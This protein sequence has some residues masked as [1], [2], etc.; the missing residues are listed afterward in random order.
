[1]VAVLS[2]FDR[3]FLG[4]DEDF[5]IIGSGEIG[6][7]A[8]GLAAIRRSIAEG[9][10]PDRFPDFA[11]GIPRS[12]VIATDC[13]DVFM[14][15]NN[16]YDFLRADDYT[17]ERIA[18]EFQKADL[19]AFLV[20]DLLS[21][22]KATCQPLA[23]RSSSL[24]EDAKHEPFAGI[25]ETKMIPNNQHDEKTR[26]TRLIEAI[27]FVYAS[28][29]FRAAREYRLGTG[30]ALEDEKM[31]VLIQE[32][33]G[34]RHTDRFY[35]DISGVGRSYNFYCYGHARPDDGVVNLALGLGKT[36]VDGGVSWT[37]CPRYPQTQ[38]PYVSFDQ[39]MKES[40]NDFW[41]V[42]MGP[43]PSYDPI[44]ETEYLVRAD[45]RAAEDD[46]TLKLLASTYDAPNNRLEMGVFGTG[47]RVITF[48]PLLVG[49]MLPLNEVV[50]ALLELSETQSG[51][52]VEIEFAVT[53]EPD[54]PARF[55]FLQ[56]RPMVVS[57]DKVEVSD[58]ELRAPETLVAA[59]SALGNGVNDK[60]DH[61]VYL[62]P[63][64]FEQKNTRKI[65]GE[66]SEVNAFL[67]E[68]GRHYLLIG[69]G[70]WGSTDPWL[71]I[72]VTWGQIGNARAI[73]EVMLPGMY[74]DLSQGSHFFHNLNG[75]QVS[76]FSLHAHE[77]PVDWAALDTCD[78]LK[79]T[80]H[81]RCVKLPA[82]LHIKVDGR[83]GRGVIH[84]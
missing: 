29:F 38:P 44:E 74:I 15:I 30:H 56:V 72:P 84:R 17:D 1:M 54:G 40:Q 37:Y 71:G 66:L 46:N 42:N 6:G 76:Y 58:E 12:T 81:V 45:L 16:L 34:R 75:F 79:E 2:K 70:R 4:S 13:F 25:Y 53:L 49:R 24:L 39:L 23:V 5:T 69:F 73:V 48:A 31:A 32:V 61:V 10:P 19:P 62:K 50:K 21:I 18:M 68:A 27:K 26:F 67:R 14:K 9:F 63:D 65:V 51:S 64:V 82:P 36:I 78:A 7:K 35:P 47:P 20:G 41:A 83:T 8:H 60:I 3:S 80:T 55:A 57:H 52:E 11:V 77:R 59:T 33:V 22:V 43:V 28:T